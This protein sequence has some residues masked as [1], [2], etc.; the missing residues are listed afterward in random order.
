VNPIFGIFFKVLSGI[1]FTLMSACIK[2]LGTHH[3]S[4]QI[5]PVGEVVFFRSFLAMWTVVVWLALQGKLRASIRTKNPLGHVQRGLVGS[6]GM[7]FGFAALAFLPLPDA[8][9]LG[10]VA[11]LLT[12]MLAALLL[13][14]SVGIY[15]WGAVGFGM[16]GI[17]GTLWPHLGESRESMVEGSGFGALC[18]LAAALCTAF[19]IIEVRKLTA[20]EQ[21]G[22]IVL[23]FSG[24]TSC[25]GLVT[26]ILGLF[27]PRY[28]W[29]M[30]SGFEAGLVVL[31]GFF[32]GI[33]QI[34]LT[35]SYRHA[36][37][38][39]IAPFDYLNLIWAILLGWVLFAERPETAL[40]FGA[41]IVIAAG[42]FVLW[43]EHRLGI[44]RKREKAAAPPRSI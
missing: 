36:E 25:F 11:P 35:E 15:R 41:S 14:E 17:I 28:A 31:I 30:P 3:M 9:A 42:L 4:E 16:V 26:L 34:L 13:H 23:Y 43:R 20:T 24:L 40:I 19:A 38:S 18:G 22:T 27:I 33:G 7:F 29:Q 21:T 37:P 44:Q 32:G 10:Y 1:A 39:V 12:V 2:W 6:G 8:T 5:Y